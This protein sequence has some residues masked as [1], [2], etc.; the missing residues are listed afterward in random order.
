MKRY[1][2]FYLS[3]LLIIVGMSPHLDGDIGSSFG[4][5]LIVLV[6]ISFIFVFVE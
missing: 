1:E 4:P 2:K 3:L 6:I 5:M